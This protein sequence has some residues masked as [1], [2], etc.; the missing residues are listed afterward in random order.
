M[1]VAGKYRPFD[2]L[3][4]FSFRQ[5]AAEAGIELSL[6]HE[7]RIMDAYNE[8]SPY[9]E[10]RD[11]FALLQDHQDID[12]WIFSNGTRAMIT[13]SLRN[14]RCV[15]DL[16]TSIFP[17]ERVVTIDDRALRVFKPDPRTYKFMAST[18]GIQDD[19]G[20]GWL[21]SCNPFDVAGAESFG[22]KAAWIDRGGTGWVDGL[23]GAL[24]IRPTLVVKG[25]DEAVRKI[26]AFG[27]G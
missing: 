22:L 13:S 27:T 6:D 7:E 5:A 1:Q 16:A 4:R 9:P 17:T 23:G 24:G 19:L 2:E 21:V 20:S 3:T 12:P 15:S 18:A 25:V 26:L 11:A 14:C 10:V 8:L